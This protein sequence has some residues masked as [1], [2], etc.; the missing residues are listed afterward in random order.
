MHLNR[1]AGLYAAIAIIC[2]STVATAFK[3][4]LAGMTP[5][6]LLFISTL[7]ALLALFLLLRAGG[8]RK[9]FSSVSSRDWKRAAF[10][11]FINPFLYYL[12]L[13]QAYN[14]LPAQ[15]AQALNMI[16]P[17]ILVLLS[18]PI[19]GQKIR[20]FSMVAMLISFSGALLIATQG[21]FFSGQGVQIK[22]PVGVVLA[23][24]SAFLWALYF[25]LNMKN[26]L[27]DDLSLFLNFLFASIYIFLFEGISWLAGKS[28]PGVAG[29][30][31]GL[32]SIL[33]AV[34]V[35][36]FE[37]AIPFVIWLKALKLARNTAVVS[38]LIY[39]FPF[40]SLLLI[41][42]I[43]GEP[44]YPTTLWGLVLIIGGVLLSR[45][46]EKNAKSTM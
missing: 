14:V 34:Y 32:K 15:V 38:S 18:I 21:T 23:A 29:S 45:I 19:L 10:L 7:T 3:W 27:P 24:S 44:V 26:N 4:A 2:W 41:H 25:L 8:K 11:G 30:E 12:I 37:M 33:S 35:G 6:R 39:I 42:F 40:L 43:L 1:S 20:W 16:W 22:N 5:V 13:F 36:L 28:A 46:K 9:I 17:L 31:P